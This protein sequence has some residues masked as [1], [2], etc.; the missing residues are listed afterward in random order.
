MLE[1]QQLSVMYYPLALLRARARVHSHSHSTSFRRSQFPFFAHILCSEW[2]S[3][4]VGQYGTQFQ[5][6]DMLFDISRRRPMRVRER[7]RVREEGGM[8][9]MG[10]W[11]SFLLLFCISHLQ[12]QTG[13]ST[14]SCACAAA[15]SMVYFIFTRLHLLVFV[16]CGYFVSCFYCDHNRHT[17]VWHRRLATDGDVKTF[18]FCLFSA[19][20]NQ[21]LTTMTP[22]TCKYGN[23]P[24]PISMTIETNIQIFIVVWNLLLWIARMA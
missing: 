15:A 18:P 16:L 14:S 24:T 12:R 13:T 6:C 7:E 5:K 8:D 4:S 11:D 10:G 2:V 20:K 3:N 19:F 23:E 21:I 9:A 22:F 1:S 17:E